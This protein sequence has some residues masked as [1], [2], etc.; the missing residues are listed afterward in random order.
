MAQKFIY[1]CDKCKTEHTS[2]YYG[3]PDGWADAVLRVN[4]GYDRRLLFCG[5]CKIAL[6]VDKLE[7]QHATDANTIQDRL[8][9]CIEE[10]VQ[11]AID[12][13]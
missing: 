8:F 11:E 3:K 1:I 9:A 6:G 13:Q 12:N 7:K 2:K 4:S 10:M 5:K